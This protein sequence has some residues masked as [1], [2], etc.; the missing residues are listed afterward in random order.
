MRNIIL[1]FRYVLNKLV[2]FQYN[3]GEI[4]KGYIYLRNI[5]RD[6]ISI[7]DEEGNEVGGYD[8]DAFGNHVIIKDEDNIATIN[9]FRSWVLF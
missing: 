4:T 9:P 2:G 8:Y 7:I 6:I 1:T 3:D 5:Q